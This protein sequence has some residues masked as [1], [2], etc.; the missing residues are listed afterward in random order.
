MSPYTLRNYRAA[1]DEFRAFRPEVTWAAASPADFRDFLF[2]LSK[3]GR[4]KTSIRTTFAGLRSFFR[5]SLE[6]GTLKRNPVESIGL[7]KKQKSLPAFL[8][9][10]QVETLLGTPGAREK[11]KQAPAWMA[12]RDAAILELLYS[13]GMRLAELA[14]LNVSHVDAVTETVRVL[15]KGSKERICPMGEAAAAAI[16]QYRLA[17]GV[18]SGPLFLNKSRKRLSRRSIWLILKKYAGEGNLPST[19]SPHKLRHTFATHMLDAGADLRSV[20]TLLGHASLSTTQIYTHVTTER[21]KSVYKKAHPR[22]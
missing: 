6:R 15:G 11:T 17:A 22:A 4:K 14:G 16:Q 10:G 7:P 12:L 8:T 13:T 21:M 2:A 5:F 3:Q 18:H 9:Q 20:Q 19:V 1:L